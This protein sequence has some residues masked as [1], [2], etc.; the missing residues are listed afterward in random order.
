MQFG[1]LPPLAGDG[2]ALIPGYFVPL[3][4][5][6]GEGEPECTFFYPCKQVI[7]ADDYFLDVPVFQ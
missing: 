4:V 3:A 6:D 2:D 7:P 5:R 1:Y